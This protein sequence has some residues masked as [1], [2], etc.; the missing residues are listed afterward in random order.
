SKMNQK[1]K[2]ENSRAALGLVLLHNFNGPCSYV[3][4]SGWAA[5]MKLC[6]RRTMPFTFPAREFKARA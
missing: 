5:G 6:G 4:G 3:A 2:A 1:I